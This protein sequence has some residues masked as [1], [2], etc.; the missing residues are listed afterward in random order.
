MIFPVL[1]INYN[2]HSHKEN[3]EVTHRWLEIS[4][5]NPKHMILTCMNLWG[6]THDF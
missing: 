6:L 3:L 4:D 2:H 5:R 1:K